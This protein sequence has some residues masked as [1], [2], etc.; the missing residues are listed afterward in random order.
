MKKAKEILNAINEAEYKIYNT[1][2]E[3][4]EGLSPETRQTYNEEDIRNMFIGTIYGQTNSNTINFLRSAINK[5]PDEW[6]LEFLKVINGDTVEKI[7]ESVNESKD[8]MQFKEQNTDSWTKEKVKTIIGF[9]INVP[10]FEEKYGM[11]VNKVDTGY[12]LKTRSGKQFTIRIE[13][14][15]RDI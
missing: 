11:E 9:L 2:E 15:Q 10:E 12:V 13:N 5:M 14:G 8:L 4:E 7:S 6:V 1:Q 3:A